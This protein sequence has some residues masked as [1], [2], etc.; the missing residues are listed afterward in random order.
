M[1]T[2]LLFY[3][4]VVPILMVSC[5]DDIFTNMRCR[6]FTIIYLLFKVFFSLFSHKFNGGQSAKNS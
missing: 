4:Y 6:V 1:R 3:L 2:F 5:P